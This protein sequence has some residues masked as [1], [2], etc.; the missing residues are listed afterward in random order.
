M[1]RNL[2]NHECV[3]YMGKR[4]PFSNKGGSIY[5]QTFYTY[6]ENSGCE[7]DKVSF[8]VFSYGRHFPMYVYDY[9]TQRWY[10]NKD[11][12]SRTTSKHQTLMRPRIVEDW[13]DTDTL[14]AIASRGIVKV[15][16]RRLAA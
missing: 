8:A 1:K 2:T 4:E 13:Y 5:G 9:A 11:K 14:S 3:V 15:V 10:G 12:Y 6:D 7:E 16:E